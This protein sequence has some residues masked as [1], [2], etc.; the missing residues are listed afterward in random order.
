[1]VMNR[2]KAKEEMRQALES[3]DLGNTWMEFIHDGFPKDLVDFYV[4]NRTWCDSEEALC[5]AYLR[6]ASESLLRLYGNRPLYDGADGEMDDFTDDFN[7]LGETL[8]VF[9][10]ALLKEG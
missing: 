6:E 2:E 8:R 5:H 4:V 7:V 10:S 3:L 1:M 9:S